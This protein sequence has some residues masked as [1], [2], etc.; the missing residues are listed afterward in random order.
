MTQYT[1]NFVALAANFGVDKD[2]FDH[3]ETAKRFGVI[4]ESE[5][6]CWVSTF[7]D[8][9]EALDQVEWTLINERWWTPIYLVDL[10]DFSARELSFRPIIELGDLV[11]GIIANETG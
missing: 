5:K 4:F 9:A 1:E 7:E 3:A 10:I 8:Q 11:E 6:G 2:N